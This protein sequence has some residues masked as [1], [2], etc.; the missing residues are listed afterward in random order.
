MATPAALARRV[1]HI[2]CTQRLPARIAARF[3][4]TAAPEAAKPA[5]AAPVK[6]E[7]KEEKGTGRLVGRVAFITGAGSGI[8]REMALLF[9]R[10]GAKVSCVD[11][12]PATGQE[13]ASMI[14][15]AH[16]NDRALFVRADVSCSVDVEAAVSMSESV[17]GKIDTLVNNAGVVDPEDD[18]AVTTDE[19][20]FDNTLAVNL[21]GVFLGCKYGIP[22]LRRA[23]GGAIINVAS[24]VALLGSATPNIAYTASKGGVLSLTRELAVLHAREGIRVNALCPGPVKTE[25]LL[26]ELDTEE[27]RK[28][29][30]VHIP[31]GRFA[32][33]REVARG[34]LFLASDD[35]S[36]VTGTALNLDG[37]IT[38]AYTTPE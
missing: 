28:R 9:A 25:Q 21:K 33:P 12:D 37:G 11:V 1:Q 5:D 3:L 2:Q 24:F 22:A 18:N 7:K 20:V 17:F 4:S 30:M 32:E 13:T 23:K 16:G 27:K 6:E 38:A 34:A 36:F 8:G 14:M 26:R 15:K 10:E 19:D 35:A 29:R 31:M